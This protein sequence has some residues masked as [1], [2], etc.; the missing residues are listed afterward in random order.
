[1]DHECEYAKCSDLF[2]GSSFALILRF[3]ATG[4]DQKPITLNIEYATKGDGDILLVAGDEEESFWFSRELLCALSTFFKNLPPSSKAEDT[5]EGRQKLWLEGST[6][7]GLHILL[8]VVQSLLSME[9]IAYLA[10]M[11]RG[12][13]GI[14]GAAMASRRYELLFVPHLLCQVLNAREVTGAFMTYGIWAF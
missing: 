11:A 2:S 9:P 8:K 4:S 13:Q 12:S 6:S 1:M 10:V 7:Q 5:Y 14:I 3:T